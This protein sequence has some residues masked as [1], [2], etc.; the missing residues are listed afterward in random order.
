MHYP[1]W[2]IF[3]LLTCNHRQAIECS[4]NQ[5][6]LDAILTN[7]EQQ[8]HELVPKILWSAATHD[9][10]LVIK[11]KTAPQRRYERDLSYQPLV[12]LH[13]H[14]SGMA[15]NNG[16]GYVELAKIHNQFL[17]DYD[18]LVATTA[19]SRRS[20]T[21]KYNTVEKF[22]LVALCDCPDML[23]NPATQ[24]TTNAAS[25]LLK[26]SNH[27][28][29]Y[30]HMA[31]TTILAT[32]FQPRPSLAVAVAAT[33]TGKGSRWHYNTVMDRVLDMTKRQQQQPTLGQSSGAPLQAGNNDSDANATATDI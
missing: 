12:S 28:N 18:I 5:L 16:K 26:K 14:G 27:L 4:S 6:P 3:Y 25:L 31:R 1:F 22:P 8:T 29:K 20:I 17:R 24:L 32:T 23:K 21:K 30:L 7:V 2:T 9:L 33:G 15:A 11:P 19:T 10:G 13:N